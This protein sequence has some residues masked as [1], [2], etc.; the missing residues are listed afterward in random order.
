MFP[1]GERF[2]QNELSGSFNLTAYTDTT[3]SVDTEDPQHFFLGSVND[4]VMGMFSAGFCTQFFLTEF[5]PAFGTNPR[6]DSVR[7]VMPLSFYSFGVQSRPKGILRANLYELSSGLPKDQGYTNRTNPFTY[8]GTNPVLSSFALFPDDVRS[9]SNPGADN[10]IRLNLPSAFGQRFLDNS[11]ELSTNA[12][13]IQLFRGLAIVPDTSFL[14]PGEGAILSIK[15]ADLQDSLYVDI[16]FSNDEGQSSRY[17]LQVRSDCAKFNFFK[18]N[19]ASA[20]P[21][22]IALRDTLAGKNA[23]YVQSLGVQGVIGFPFATAWRDSMPVFI[24]KAELSIPV[25]TTDYETYAAPSSFIL[26]YYEE[27]TKEWVPIPDYGLGSDFFAGTYASGD[28]EIKFNIPVYL[29]DIITGKR[30]NTGLR[31][32]PA[33]QTELIRRIRLGGSDKMKLK[34]FY[35]KKN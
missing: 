10:K 22:G 34:L 35:A 21:F 17:R 23:L 7:L 8:I 29:Q 11:G 32:V 31:I 18:N 12:A 13:L 20:S 27:A 9:N 14:E 5:S 19:P 26:Q 4:S 30:S 16:F 33:D 25:N 15:P 3:A 6:C 28:P 1:D 2:K 24:Q